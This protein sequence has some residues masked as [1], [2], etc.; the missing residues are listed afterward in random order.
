MSSQD[1]FRTRVIGIVKD[2]SGKLD[3]PKG[4]GAIKAIASAPTAGG[5]GYSL[6]D[7]LTISG[8]STGATAKITAVSAGA[9]AAVELVTRGAGYTSGSGKATTVAPAGGTGCTLEIVSVMSIEAYDRHITAALER[10]SKHKPAVTVVDMAGNG[11]HD[12]AIPAGW[13]DEFSSLVSIEYPVGDVPESLLDEDDYKIYQ[14][15]SAKKVRLINDVPPVGV[16][17]RVSFTI[18][19][20]AITVPAGDVDAVAWLAAS[21]CL[22]ELANAF[23]QTG[24]STI[25]ADVVNYRS[26]SS[27][28]AARAKRLMQLYKEH[29]GLKDGDTAPAAA[30]IRDFEQKKYPGGLDRLTHPRGARE[31]R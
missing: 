3:D 24:D 1:D 22:E 29:M 19:R 27:E 4:I 17:F 10:Y 8:G 25:A 9:V 23:A 6:N 5:T 21:L 16:S 12:Y 15:T 7:V 11:T 26:K 28:F 30:V 14:T 20:T 2:D 13:V 18:P 31:R